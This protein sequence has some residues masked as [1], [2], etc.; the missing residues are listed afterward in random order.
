[1]TMHDAASAHDDAFVELASAALEDVM[2]YYPDWASSLGDH[3]YDDQ[4]PD[5][6]PATL[7][8]CRGV[9]AQHADRLATLDLTALHAEN[10]VDAKMLTNQLAALQYDLEDLREH[11]WNPMVANP[12]QAIYTLLARDFAPLGDRLHA[13]AG[14]LAAIPEA[15]ATSRS[16]LGAMPRVHIETAL[17]QFA[18]TAA[19][20]S[21]EIDALLESAPASRA[22]IEAVRPAALEAIET[23]RRWI[24]E[25]LAESERD[26]TFRDPRIGAERF[27]HKLALAL[28]AESDADAILSRAEADLERVSEEIAE[29]AARRLGAGRQVSTSEVVHRVLDQ[30]AADVPDDATILGF[31]RDALADQ[32]EFV[33]QNGIATTY[34]DPV[35]VIVMPEINRGVAVAYCDPP[36]P[37]EEVEL[38]TFV[39]VS[40]TP[41]DWTAEQVASFYRE[42][43]RHMVH[44]LMVH[45]AMPGH[46]LQL[47]HSRRFVGSSRVRAA[48]WSGSFV[49]GWGVYAESVM[50]GLG[51]PGEN[52]P[53]AMHLQQLKMRLRCIV[54]AI[55]DARVHGHGMTETEATRLMVERGFQEVGEV[56]GKWRRALLTSA[57]LSTYYVGV[58]E[59]DDLVADVKRD[60][61]DWS[62]RELHDAVLGHGSP[63]VRHLR[64]LITR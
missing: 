36:G 27:T 33:Q 56:A 26:G 49:E 6:S 38:P 5:A 7:D 13:V 11:T 21:G 12:G 39:A 57:Q 55:L 53:D 42:Y 1:M 10:R 14:R 50:A 58:S 35:E 2:R 46:V 24:Y 4:L 43:N 28:D 52:D 63:T 37:L 20:I 34:E 23:H 40:P 17:G 25:R 19:L 41:S 51:Y 61:S 18:G 54:N 8:Q 15:L 48:F 47:Q 22:E 29:V 59:V 44:N 64:M 31:A 3:R 62:M 9:L 45:E 30:L 16:A 60:H 32:L